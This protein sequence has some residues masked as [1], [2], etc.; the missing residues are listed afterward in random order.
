MTFHV[1]RAS[2]HPEVVTPHRGSPPLGPEIIKAI[3]NSITKCRLRIFLEK[4]VKRSIFFTQ[5]QKN[6]F[7]KS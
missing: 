1:P 3:I 7:K 6:K 2:L 4:N 5:F